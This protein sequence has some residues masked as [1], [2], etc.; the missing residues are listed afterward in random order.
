MSQDWEIPRVRNR[1]TLR[2]GDSPILA[3]TPEPLVHRTTADLRGLLSSEAAAW[4]DA[5]ARLAG[6][7]RWFRRHRPR[8]PTWNDCAT[9]AGLLTAAAFRARLSGGHA[10]FAYVARCRTLEARDLRREEALWPWCHPAD[11]FDMWRTL[12]PCPRAMGVVGHLVRGWRPWWDGRLGR[13]PPP[14]R[15]DLTRC[16][17]DCLRRG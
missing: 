6:A 16:W 3:A 10:L 2:R 15:A 11:A 4:G 17:V 14:C 7:E 8:N 1:H 13:D 5:A 12:F 9:R